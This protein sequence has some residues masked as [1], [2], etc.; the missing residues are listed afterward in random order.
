MTFLPQGGIDAC[1]A[2]SGGPLRCNGKLCGIISFGLKCAVKDYP[3]LH[4]NNFFFGEGS[5]KLVRFDK[6]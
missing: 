5:K 6:Q 1:Q 2:D 4:L 3:G